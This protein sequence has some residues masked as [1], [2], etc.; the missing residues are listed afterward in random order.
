MALSHHNGCIRGFNINKERQ[1]RHLLKAVI[2][3]YI[4]EQLRLRF[5][6]AFQL[7]G[8]Y[9]S[10]ESATAVADGYEVAEILTTVSESTRRVLAGEAEYER[11]GVL[12][13]T[14]LCDFRMLSLLL[15][16][17]S[18]QGG[19]V[20]VVDVGG[21][22]ASTYLQHRSW[23]VDLNINWQVLEQPHFVTSGNELFINEPVKFTDFGEGLPDG[24][25]VV[26]LK[27]VLQY[28]ASPMDLVALILARRPA[29]IYL[30]RTPCHEGLEHII[31]VQRVKAHVYNGYPASYASW[32]FARESLMAALSDGYEIVESFSDE[33]SLLGPGGIK[34]NYLGAVLRRRDLS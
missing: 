23:F 18:R 5:G 33:L 15:A 2:P 6:G 26:L 22:L 1:L 16:V 12:H 7:S 31:T 32:L 29:F 20:S 8:V 9:E 11:D 19:Q 10:W 3:P 25:D 21:S 4:T 14:P 17:A 24:C 13:E 34:V 27:S 30:E 28:L